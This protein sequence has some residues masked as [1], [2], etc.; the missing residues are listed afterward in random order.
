[1]AEPHCGHTKRP[2]RISTVPNLFLEA[3]CSPTLR[4]S[5]TLASQVRGR[6][7]R[8]IVPCSGRRA[9]SA[10]EE[11]A[12]SSDMVVGHRHCALSGGS[13][14]PQHYF[15]IPDSEFAFFQSNIANYGCI[16]DREMH[17][18]VYYSL[19]TWLPPQ[20]HLRTVMGCPPFIL[21]VC[22]IFTPP[23]FSSHMRYPYYIFTIIKMVVQ[24]L[25]GFW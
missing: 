4:T 11:R 15:C 23:P 13:Y 5:L 6:N 18:L 12:R 19:R 22:P 9:I 2:T 17:L 16:R 24:S 20:V 8:T 7:K 25:L 21:Q 1:M 10:F 3:K 14:C